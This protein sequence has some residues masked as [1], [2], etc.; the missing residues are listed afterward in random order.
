[1]V[2]LASLSQSSRGQPNSWMAGPL[3]LATRKGAGSSKAAL[4]SQIDLLLQYYHLLIQQDKPFPDDPVIMAMPEEPVPEPATLPD[5]LQKLCKVIRGGLAPQQFLLDACGGTVGDDV[6]HPP[7]HPLQACR[8]SSGAGSF[9]FHQ[10]RWS[11]RKA[12]PL[13]WRRRNFSSNSGSSGSRTP[14]WIS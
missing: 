4:S 11:T 8:Y 3:A 10:E 5:L 14:S 2:P 12:A 9:S 7:S 13:A 6:V 1:M